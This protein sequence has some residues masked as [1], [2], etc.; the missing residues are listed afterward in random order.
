[1]ARLATEVAGLTTTNLGSGRDKIFIRGLSDGAFTGRTQSTVGLYLDDVPITYNAPDPDLLLADV[2][3]VEVLR[4]PQGTLY[5]AG[6]IGG[7]VR[8]VTNKPDLTQ[9]GGS[10]SIGAATTTHSKSSQLAIA[11]VNAP[12]VRD[13]LAVRAVGY[14]QIK[15]GYIDNVGLGL[16]NVNRTD[17]TG[18]RLLITFKPTEDLSIN[19]GVTHQSINAADTQ[20]A[21]R[22]LGP[23]QT[24]K[25]LHEPHDNDFDQAFLSVRRSLA[26]ADAKVSV[27]YVNHDVSSRYD[28]SSAFRNLNRWAGS[29]IAFDERQQVDLTVIE[30]NLTSPT[31]RPLTW[32]SGVFF[33]DSQE[34]DRS[35]AEALAVGETFYVTD[36]S[37]RLTETAAYGEVSYAISNRVHL[38]GGL[39]WFGSKLS[40]H[41]SAEQGGV[42]TRFDG[43]LA[44]TDV[45]P[46][47]VLSISEDSWLIYANVSQGYRGGGFNGE[48][49]PGTLAQLPRTFQPDELWSYEV[50][51]RAS[52]WD[53]RLHFRL[54]VFQ[55]D[56]TDLQSDQYLPSGLPVTLNIGNGANTGLEVEGRYAANERLAM[57]LTFL[58]DRPRLTNTA[59]S[60]PARAQEGLPGVPSNSGGAWITYVWRP[61]ARFRVQLKVETRYVGPSYLT[62]DS[63]S[64]G[65][66]GGYAVTGVSASLDADR[67]RLDGYVDNIADE[68]ANTFAHG[69]PFSRP[70][71]A[72][73]TPLRP[74]TIGLQLTRSF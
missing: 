66:Q 47:A 61:A 22:A 25:R 5:G 37:D 52:L 2:K 50:G 73:V 17:R 14:R 11:A 12:I 69:N 23:L 59:G 63:A 68:T 30:A 41:A 39:R 56:W 64:P 18:G 35:A 55:A 42:G 21:L 67:W 6:S 33:S 43:R 26:G 51:A 72:Q 3:Q 40:T 74:R 70:S 62:F 38:T 65:R 54:A 46:K 13:T 45:S 44:N 31:D 60:F 28:A 24:S 8:I 49:R 32:L 16:T 53:Q 19:A 7:I 58:I 10:L 1:M 9:Y 48:P 15:G 36:R 29:S 4:G 71:R 57:G 27:A 34:S 20:Y